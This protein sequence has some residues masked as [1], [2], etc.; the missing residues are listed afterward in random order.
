MRKIDGFFV[1]LC[2]LIATSVLAQEVPADS[3]FSRV[4][5]VSVDGLAADA[6][7]GD[8]TFQE[9]FRDGA[10]VRGETVD[11]PSTLP[12]HASL[13]TA[14]TPNV[15]GIS[16]NTYRA[17]YGVV[18]RE[19]IFEVF[20]RAG[21]RTS[22]VVSAAP[23]KRKLTHVLPTRYLDSI[24][25]TNDPR[26]AF[27]LAAQALQHESS[28]VFVHLAAPD[29]VG[30]ADGWRSP[31]YYRT[32]NMIAVALRQVLSDF[33]VP[34]MLN[35]EGKT[36][37]PDDLLVV[38]TA[39]HGGFGKTHIPTYEGYCRYLARRAYADGSD[40]PRD[41]RYLNCLEAE[42]Q[43]SIYRDQVFNIP[44]AVRGRGIRS[45]NDRSLPGNYRIYEVAPT[46]MRLVGIYLPEEWRST[47]IRKIEMEPSE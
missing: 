16:W 1:V 7:E 11:P 28:F 6:F 39:D 46:I 45:V 2:S 8:P 30:H 29:D 15:H 42:K 26:E 12:A 22:A 10:Y 37:T 36:K 9:V 13:L 19:T 5:L 20:K 34:V 24:A 35:S 27:M 43:N 33:R 17:D 21:W 32:V 41:R 3:K 38:L 47:Q 23:A 14:T 44:I 4:L 40:E 25:S 18:R 31:A